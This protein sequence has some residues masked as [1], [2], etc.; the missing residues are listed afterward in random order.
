MFTYFIKTSFFLFCLFM[1]FLGN[2]QIIKGQLVDKLSSAGIIGARLFIVETEQLCVSDSSGFFCF[3][4]PPVFP[5][6]I[7]IQAA[8][9]GSQLKTIRDIESDFIL[10][11][12]NIT[13]SQ[14][15][16][17]GTIIDAETN[18]YITGASIFISDL[19]KSA[20]SNKEGYFS[21][22]AIRS[23]TY[24]IEISHED[25]KNRI[26]RITIKQDTTLTVN[27]SFAIAEL[28]QVII[29]AVT[30]STELKISPLIIKPIDLNYLN[31]G[32]STNL[33]DALKNIPGVN[34]ITNGSGISKPTIRGLGYNRVITLFN[35]IRQEGQQ[36][37]DEHGIEID[38]YSVDRIEIVKGPGSL[39]YGSDGIAGVLNF[40]SPKS[41]QEGKIKTRLITNYQ[42]NNQLLGYS[43][44]NSGRKKDYQWSAQLSSK[45]AGNYQNKFDGK[46]YN[47]GFQECSGNIFIGLNKKWGYSHLH[48]SSFNTILNMIEGER[49][50]LGNFVHETIDA[51]GNN[52]IVTAKPED[53]KGYQIGFPHQA[54]NHTRVTSNNLFL[55]KKGSIN[56]DLGFQNNRRKEFGDLSN[57]DNKDLF[58]DL[59][60]LNYN[61]RYN[62]T[63][64]KHWETSFGMSGMIQKNKNKGIEFLIPEYSSLD[65]G[66]FV[67][68]QKTI[69]KFTF[70][71][72]IRLDNRYINTDL[73]VL[74]SLGNS[75]VALDSLS[76]IKFSKIQRSFSSF[77]GSIGA[78]YQLNKFSTFKLNFSRGFRAPNISEM[79]SNG[80]HEGTL[81]YEYGNS[82]L[83]SEIS[84]QLDLAFFINKDHFS[85]ELT[86]FINSV[87]N[88]IYSEK[89]QSVFGGDSIPDLSDPTAAFKF[90]QGNA[91]LIGTEIYMDIHPHPLDWLHIENSFS[92]V[93]ATLNNQLDS[94]KYLPFIPAPKYR[95]ELRAQF[96]KIGRHLSSVYLKLAADHYF[97]QNN[98]FK[99]YDTE[100]ATPGYSLISAGVGAS[101]FG[102]NQRTIFQVFISGENL[103]NRAYQSH[104]SRLKYAPLNP[105]SGRQ[106]VYNMGRNLSIKFIVNLN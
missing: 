103:T 25:Y 50:S 18:K 72:G 71:G 98:Y 3:R 34:Q 90:T 85:L 65:A 7:K 51:N 1:S 54:I 32:S 44:S 37:G 43:L 101:I 56:F 84:H 9:Y 63:E 83:K 102:K 93:R 53:M 49:D 91:T 100:S 14:F 2:S 33:I 19:N 41:P 67:F 38:E 20:N 95:A 68:T 29:T 59:S 57:P 13:T 74:D 23:G 8:D 35:G 79:S 39:M 88:Y 106:G 55:L 17:S 16:V 12:E 64:K 94:T 22:S 96:K 61:L 58:F 89:I 87:F 81:R 75:T 60:T 48:A 31:Q 26:D 66:G 46:V 27:L 62:L 21:F 80:K 47:S 30:R 82:N 92:F 78:S 76:E 105:A 69:K 11:I 104:L 52:S 97:K 36:W 42:T 40:I 70:A 77:S 5:F 6:R 15:S 4:Q 24:F 10:E 86:P 73:L 28:N 45:L 99:A